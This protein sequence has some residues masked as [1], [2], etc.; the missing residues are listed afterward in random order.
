MIVIFVIYL[1]LGV[2]NK[3]IMKTHYD[4]FDLTTVGVN[5]KRIRPQKT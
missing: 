3:K 4:Q 1:I 5:A 2:F